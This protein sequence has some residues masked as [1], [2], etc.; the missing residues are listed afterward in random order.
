MSYIAFL[1]EYGSQYLNGALVTV[2]QFVAAALIAVVIA[3]LF[4]LLSLSPSLILRGFATIYIEFF[5]GTSLL[6]QL[7]WLFYV[8]PLFG[9]P[10]DK[11]WTG[12]IAVGLNLGAYG[13]QL[14]RTAILSTPR[15]Q[16]EA[17][18]A[19]SMSP[20]K[21]MV[22]IILPQAI[23]TMLPAWG[24]LMVE[25]LKST[26][27]VA[28]IAVPDIMFSSKQINNTTYLSTWAFGTAL[29]MYYILARFMVTPLSRRF[30][31]IMAKRMGRK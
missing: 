24:N 17:A 8:L 15:G 30:E 7:F 21:R 26:A 16:W 10:L 9:V 5:R 4:G 11:A 2:I 28:L 20:Y 25:L 31:T 13:A 22:R 19:L 3:H 6:V 29:A 1:T 23:V 18:Y 14:V 27:L 12:F